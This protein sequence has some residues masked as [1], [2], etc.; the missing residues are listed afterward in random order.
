MEKKLYYGSL[1]HGDQE[2]LIALS[3]SEILVYTSLISHGGRDRILKLSQKK[4][5]SISGVSIGSCKRALSKFKKL[6]WLEVSDFYQIKQYK[7]LMNFQQVDHS[8]DLPKESR[9]DHSYDPTIDHSCDPPIDHLDDPHVLNYKKEE[10][11]LTCKNWN[12]DSLISAAKTKDEIIF[13]RLYDRWNNCKIAKWCTKENQNPLLIWR[14]IKEDCDPHLQL[15]L[16]LQIIDSWLLM[17]RV[18]QTIKVWRFAN[19]TRGLNDWLKRQADQ[20]ARSSIARLSKRQKDFF[21]YAIT[22]HE[23]LE[24]PS[25]EVEGIIIPSTSEVI[26]DNVVYPPFN[27]NLLSNDANLYLEFLLDGGRLNTDHNWAEVS[28]RFWT[29]PLSDLPEDIQEEVLQK[30]PELK[31]LHLVHKWRRP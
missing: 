14:K 23:T 26:A 1:Y 5:A 4:I 30:I 6:K 22:E 8:Y 12:F 19:W 24:P 31:H 7:I 10:N 11:Q 29:R 20:G 16:E 17:K 15:S 25:L 9:V 3:R 28:D 18:D 21:D 27:K 2:R 13:V